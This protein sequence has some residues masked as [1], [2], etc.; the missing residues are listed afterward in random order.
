MPK[1]ITQYSANVRVFAFDGGRYLF[2]THGEHAAH[3]LKSGRATVH[4][5]SGVMCKAI[6]LAAHTEMNAGGTHISRGGLRAAAGLSQDY[7][8]REQRRPGAITR[9]Y[10]FKPIA[11]ADLRHFYKATGGRYGYGTKQ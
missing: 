7:I 8:E 11:V 3:L 5:Q 6:R 4:H 1:E 10:D 2:A 9:T